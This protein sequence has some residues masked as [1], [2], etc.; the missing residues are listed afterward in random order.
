MGK[1]CEGCIKYYAKQWITDSYYCILQ[2]EEGKW[3]VEN[4]FSWSG[5]YTKEQ[6]IIVQWCGG[7][8]ENK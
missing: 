7:E 3:W 5:P 1:Q 2:D 8:M 6:A 4:E